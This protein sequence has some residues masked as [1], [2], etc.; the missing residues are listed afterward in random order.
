MSGEMRPPGV[1]NSHGPGNCAEQDSK[2]TDKHAGARIQSAAAHQQAD[3]SESQKDSSEK[4][5]IPA[6]LPGSD[7]GEQENPDG[8]A[9]NEQRGK[10][11]RYFLFRPMKR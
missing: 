11:R 2:R 5:S 1:D 9:G 8:F 6:P 10:A 3:A 7:S 4:R